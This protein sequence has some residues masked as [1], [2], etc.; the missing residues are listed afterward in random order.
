MIVETYIPTNAVASDRNKSTIFLG[1]K[2]YSIRSRNCP[3][4]SNQLPTDTIKNSNATNSLVYVH[5][6]LADSTENWQSWS[7]ARAKVWS[8]KIL[9]NFQAC[10]NYIIWDHMIRHQFANRKSKEDEKNELTGTGFWIKLI[11]NWIHCNNSFS[12]RKI[13][14]SFGNSSEPKQSFTIR[15]AIVRNLVVLM[16]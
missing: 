4:F 5:S 1:A 3:P 13:A 11:L 10:S 15:W 14:L 8:P 9:S 16:K 7:A 6:F 12:Y 2:I